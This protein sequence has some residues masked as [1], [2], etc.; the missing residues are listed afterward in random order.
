MRKLAALVAVLGLII[1]TGHAWA[2]EPSKEFVGQMYLSIPFGGP[3]KQDLT[4]RLGFRVDYRG[5]E[6][7]S[8][9]FAEREAWAPNNL[10]N[11]QP[12]LDGQHA[13]LVNGVD[14]VQLSQKL[15]AAEGEGLTDGEIAL[16]VL[17][18]V[19]VGGLIYLAVRTEDCLDHLLTEDC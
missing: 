7:A 8:D 13:L 2:F 11:W 14:V 17:G 5:D 15:N 10:L 1:N 16:I 3:T 6:P 9:N 19:A 18:V 12:K 4:P